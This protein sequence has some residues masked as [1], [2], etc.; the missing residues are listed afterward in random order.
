MPS[1]VKMMLMVVP[2]DAKPGDDEPREVE[3]DSDEEARKR[4]RSGEGKLTGGPHKWKLDVP[5]IDNVTRM[6][7]E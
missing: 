1:K 2:P 5:R 3:A 4:F 6:S 7:G